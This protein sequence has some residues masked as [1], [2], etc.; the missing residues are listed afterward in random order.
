MA[1]LIIFRGLP[2]SGKTF[3]AERRVRES[4]DSGNIKTINV[5]R[6]SI[7]MMHG[8]GVAPSPFEPTVSILQ[9]AMIREGLKKGHT[10]ISSDMNLRAEYV[11]NLANIADFFGAGVEVVDFDTP[12][13]TCIMRDAQRFP[14]PDHVS[15][16]VIESIHRKFFR[17]GK[18]PQNPLENLPKAI[19][20]EPYVPDVTLPRAAIFDIDG[21]VANHEG[22]RSPYDYTKVSLDSPREA[23]VELV[24]LYASA[25]YQ[26]IFLS[27]REASCYGDT[28][29][30]IEKHIGTWTELNGFNL[31]MRPTGDKR[32]DR[33]VKGELFDQHI[34]YNYNVRV[35][36][37]DRDQVVDLV[38]KELMIN[39]MQVN[40]GNF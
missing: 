10:V 6:D 16:G 20:F 33:I 34:R 35:W 36:F 12:I 31:Y 40:Y 4:I 18:F 9:Q 24:R 8:L 32:Q 37:D 25:G 5:N 28:F 30:W 22:V 27:G 3:E 26:I 38:R 23:V 13:G 39:C 17:N 15:A 14:G 21:T 19:T 2:G 1:N 11:K 29:A 7:R